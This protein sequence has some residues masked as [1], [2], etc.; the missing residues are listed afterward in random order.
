VG[1]VLRVL[2]LNIW[3][4]EGG[5][6]DRRVEIVRWLDRLDPDLVCL[7]EVVDD[8]AGRNQAEWLAD[9]AS[10]TRHVAYG[11]CGDLGEGRSFGNAVLSRWAIESTTCTKL[12]GGH[13]RGDAGR[14]LTHAHTNGLDVFSTHL[15]SPFELGA[16]RERQVQAIVATI[17]STADPGGSL[18]PILA[19][20]FNAEPDSTE[21]RH[22]CG[23]ASMGGTSTY[24]QDAWRVA[25][26]GDPGWTWDNRNPFAAAEFEPDRRIDYVFVGWRRDDGA[27]RV[28]TA[29]V[30]CD[31]VLAGAVFATDHFG[32]L[33]EIEDAGDVP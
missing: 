2:T 20:D 31:R 7:Q 9:A 32:L 30:V 4:L 26:E 28:R 23:L 10:G 11:A 25:G 6:R 1:G 17:A 8:G 29:R 33:A 18:P 13:D 19:G 16:L 15:S 24:Y 22:L 14:G 27:G 21:I 12:P 5:W 3:N